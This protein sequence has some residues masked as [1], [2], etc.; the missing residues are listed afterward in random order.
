MAVETQSAQAGHL[1]GTSGCAP[2]LEAL[3]R[4]SGG[5]RTRAAT[6]VARCGLE[7]LGCDAAFVV[8]HGR[9]PGVVEIAAATFRGDDLPAAG[10]AWELGVAA[11]R[12]FKHSW[13]SGAGEGGLAR[14][15]DSRLGDAGLNSWASMP[16]ST[17]PGDPG[18]ALVVGGTRPGRPCARMDLLEPLAASA[19]VAL[20]GC[21]AGERAA[22]AE[23]EADERR[24]ELS[25][26]A[27]G[28]SHSLG[29]VFGAILGNLQ[30]LAGETDDPRITELVQRIDESAEAGMRLMCALRDYALLPSARQMARLDLS[31]LAREVV[32]LAR[33]L[34]AP[35]PALARVNPQTELNRPCPAWGDGAEL[36]QA[37][38]GIIFNAIEAAGRCGCI[39]VGTGIEGPRSVV[40][41][42]DDGRGMTPE[43]ARRACEPFFTTKHPPHR[44][45]GLT[46]ARGIAVAHRGSL[47]ITRPT[48]AGTVV[49]MSVAREA[50]VATRARYSHVSNVASGTP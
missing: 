8:A 32:G 48:E 36:R 37:L 39:T 15:L 12:L 35:W 42:R 40:T 22:I 17:G 23:I 18:A 30:M 16:L 34:C 47:R 11:A 5:S 13:H 20:A 50:P 45:L 19:S 43:V 7:L 31:E 14:M 44:G 46:I 49:A 21:T 38:V 33:A 9:R 24:R 6:V 10:Q 4:V 26:L 28:V 3:A 27:F 41:V 1:S 2:Q 29:N 25:N